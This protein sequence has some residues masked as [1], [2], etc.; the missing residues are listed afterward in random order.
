MAHNWLKAV[1]SG[2]ITQ[3]KYFTDFKAIA[4]ILY[5]YH[6][7][8]SNFLHLYHPNSELIF[9]FYGAMI[10]NHCLPLMN[11]TNGTYRQPMLVSPGG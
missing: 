10:A 8:F 2:L 3:G 9:N 11:K 6:P 5:F 7:K 4:I 1:E